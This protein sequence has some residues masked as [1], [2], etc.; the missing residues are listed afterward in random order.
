MDK[1][2]GEKDVV[3]GKGWRKKRSNFTARFVEFHNPRV[4]EKWNAYGNG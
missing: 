2:E 3:N 1:N 4:E